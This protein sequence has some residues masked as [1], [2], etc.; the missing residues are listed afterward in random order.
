MVW[1]EKLKV[2]GAACKS[3]K[4]HSGGSIFALYQVIF[5]IVA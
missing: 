2:G 1:G 5:Y 4:C 3:F